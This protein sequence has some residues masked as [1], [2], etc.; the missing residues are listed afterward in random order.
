MQRQIGR[1]P[2]RNRLA[3]RVTLDATAG[4][5]LIGM[6]THHRLQPGSAIG[7]QKDLLGHRIARLA[8]CFEPI[9]DHVRSHVLEGEERVIGTHRTAIG[10]DP[11]GPGGNRLHPRVRVRKHL[12]THA[13]GMKPPDSTGTLLGGRQAHKGAEKGAVKALIDAMCA[14]RAEHHAIAVRQ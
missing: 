10:V 13:I 5:G 9:G 3:G 6:K 7:T 1:Q 11:V 4:G 2:R 8:P 12:E 14:I